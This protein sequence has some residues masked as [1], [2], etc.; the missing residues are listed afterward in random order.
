MT[1]EMTAVPM[2]GTVPLIITVIG[3][4]DQFHV[5]AGEK[6]SCSSA[7]RAKFVLG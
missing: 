7:A 2:Q 3:D 6:V 1:T 5:D 4:R